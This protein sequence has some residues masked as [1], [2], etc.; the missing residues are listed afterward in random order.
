MLLKLKMASCLK[1]LNDKRLAGGI[2]ILMLAFTQSYA[3]AR[4]TAVERILQ[5]GFPTQ[6]AALDALSGSLFQEYNA[7]GNLASLIFYSYSVLKQANHFERVND[8]VRASEWA[9]TGFFYL[10]EAVDAH[11]D[12]WRVRYLRARV[13]A[14]L[15]E[16]LG[17][18]VITLEDTRAL[19]AV[20]KRYDDSL[21]A[22][23]NYLRYR[24]LRSCRMA[25]EQ[26][27]L[28]AVLQQGNAVG[29]RLLSE[30][31][32]SAPA[33]DTGEVMDVLLPLVRE[34]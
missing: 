16:T 27:Q 4:A 31:E 2:F 7:T 5:Q 12:N 9:K 23:V 30:G 17:R 20:R 28:L 33:W 19:L 22:H 26:T 29:R 34:E 1:I 13:D 21:L 18:C 6:P 25:T 3:F 8:Y 11:E 10:D 14:W 24:A 32:A 15:P